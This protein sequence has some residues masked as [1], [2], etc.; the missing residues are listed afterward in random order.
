M[1]YV[2]IGK[3]TGTHGLKGELK[4]STSFI[5]ID[6][7]LKSGFSFYIGADKERLKLEKYRFHNGKYLLTFSGF[8][9]INL[10]ERFRNN[11]VYVLRDDL[12]LKEGEF[13]F[14]DY[15]G[16]TAVFNNKEIGTV[17]DIID[18]GS[19]NYVFYIV[20]DKDILIP[21]NDM[22]IDSVLNNKIVFKEVEG[23]IDAN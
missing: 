8:E 6:R 1:G 20:G 11:D 16:M 2:C 19:N 10:V 5:Y 12:E 7:V 18:C 13:L 4:L 14:E 15:I 22:F 9:D 23:L 21:V 17:R 3:V